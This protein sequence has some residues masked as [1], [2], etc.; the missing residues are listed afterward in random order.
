[1]TRHFTVRHVDETLVRALERRASRHGRSAEAE[2]CEILRD[3][4]A[5]D[6]DRA[7]FQQALASMPDV[8][9]DEDFVFS[10][11]LRRNLE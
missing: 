1:M 3:V 2:Q 8:A 9:A 7:S 6:I 5:A 10:C 11:D 4:L